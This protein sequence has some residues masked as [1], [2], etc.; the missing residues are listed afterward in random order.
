MNQAIGVALKLLGEYKAAI[1]KVKDQIETARNLARCIENLEVTVMMIPTRGDEEQMKKMMAL[2]G[3]NT[4]DSDESK[5]LDNV[6][7]QDVVDH[8]KKTDVIVDH[9]KTD[10]NFVA[11]LS[12]CIPVSKY[13]DNFILH[14]DIILSL[15]GLRKSG[16]GLGLSYSR[17]RDNHQ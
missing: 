13:A 1:D 14:G 6:E 5:S 8:L 11:R 16:K 4:D 12:K 7:I 2:S 3:M 17:S 15:S 9:L 10:V